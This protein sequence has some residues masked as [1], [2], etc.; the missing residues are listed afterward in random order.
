M[1]PHVMP[2]GDYV[3]DVAQGG[4]GSESVNQRREREKFW[5]GFGRQ[6]AKG[7]RIRGVRG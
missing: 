5:R 4:P 1:L 3:Y 2:N 6:I 7:S